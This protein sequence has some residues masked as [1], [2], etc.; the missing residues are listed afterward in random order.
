MPEPA[1]QQSLFPE[2]FELVAAAKRALRDL[3][4][5]R[6]RRVLDSAQR[7]GVRV[8]DVAMIDAALE[9]L[10]PL[11]SDPPAGQPGLARIVQATEA[12]WR[13][14]TLSRPTAEFVDDVVA[15]FW[16]RR[17]GAE[18]FLG[19]EPQVHRGVLELVLGNGAA[20]YRSL[21]AS[22][23][24]GH[25]QR[26]ELWSYLADAAILRGRSEEAATY[27][28]RA[29]VLGAQAV[30]LLRCRWPTL[31][32]LHDELRRSHD[33][34]VARELLLPRLWLAGQLDIRPQDAWFGGSLE[35][36]AITAQSPLAERLRRFSELLC[37]DR[38]RPAGEVDE[39]R[40]EAMAEL[41]P[42]LFA[43][44]MRACRERE[45]RGR[46]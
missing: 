17:A 35:S 33:D 13:A 23:D 28:V 43:E 40:R 7:R 16:S 3:D 36:S 12:A 8:S 9:F 6:A 21:R 19:G 14:G 20:A 46:L 15:G 31:L 5:E 18:S 10:A 39:A 4:L 25:A 45:R 11:L 2:G 38:S 42:D 44:Y 22:L 26:A 37:V 34:A 32:E 27:R 1:I 30:D 41:A 24:A 29:L